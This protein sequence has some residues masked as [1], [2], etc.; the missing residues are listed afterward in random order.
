MSSLSNKIC[1]VTGSNSGIGKAT[2]TQLA[3]RGATVVL[4]VRNPEKGK[5]ALSEVVTKTGNTKTEVMNLDVSSK[6]FDKEIRRGVHSE[7]QE[8][9]YVNQQ[10]R[11]RVR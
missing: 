2:A 5:A 11:R 9:K 8:P 3:A 7:A 1:I 10:R 4:A 6:E